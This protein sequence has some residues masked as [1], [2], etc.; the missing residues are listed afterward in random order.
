MTE[1][2][3]TRC[4]HSNTIINDPQRN[5]GAGLLLIP[6]RAVHR[7]RAGALWSPGEG[8]ALG[9]SEG[10][11]EGIRGGQSTSSSSLERV[12]V[13][14][15]I[16]SPSTSPSPSSELVHL[17]LPLPLP[18]HQSSSTSSSSEVV[19]HHGPKQVHHHPP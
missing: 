13:L 11:R 6:I 8:A 3:K 7:L 19:E 17:L 2:N 15:P 14:I 16:Q 1:H 9:S 10:Q 12:G 4:E 18:P 5:R